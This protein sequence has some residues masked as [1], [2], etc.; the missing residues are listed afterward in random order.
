MSNASVHGST[1]RDRYYMLREIDPRSRK[2]NVIAIPLRDYA[3]L[4]RFDNLANRIVDLN[5]I[6]SCLRVG[7]IAPFTESLTSRRFGARLC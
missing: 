3:D 2:F 5:W 4:G 7:D 1:L 6:I